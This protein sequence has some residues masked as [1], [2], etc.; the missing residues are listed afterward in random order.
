MQKSFQFAQNF[1]GDI[2]EVFAWLSQNFSSREIEDILGNFRLYPEVLPTTEIALAVYQAILRLE[3]SKKEFAASAN[4]KIPEKVTKACRNL[5]EAVLILLDGFQPTGVFDLHSDETKVAT[6]F[7]FE[8][9]VTPKN[10][11]SKLGEIEIDFGVGA[12]QKLII[13]TDQI[14]RI[15]LERGFGAKVV[16]KV[17]ADFKIAGSKKFSGEVRGSALGLIFDGRGRPIVKPGDAG[18]KE[19]RASNWR[20]ALGE[21]Q[22]FKLGKLL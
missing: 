16:V 1:L 17:T 11:N 12:G 10:L 21:S 9:K 14:I 18:D 3:L 8:G 4:Y 6:C 22:G 7:C 13:L 15:P 5:A 20:Q 2:D 19:K